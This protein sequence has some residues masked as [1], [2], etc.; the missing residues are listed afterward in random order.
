[1]RYFIGFLVTVGLVII[2]VILLFNGGGKSKVP[3][4]TKTLTDYATTDSNVSMTIAGPIN[5]VSVHREQ[6]VTVDRNNVTFEQ[7]TG[8]DGQVVDTQVFANT[9]SAYDAFLHALQH[10]GFTRGNNSKALQ[11]DVG[12]CSTGER[13][14]F[15]LNDDGKRLQRYWSSSC[16]SPKTYQGSLNLTL[17]L[18]QAQV[19]NYSTLS[20]GV[21]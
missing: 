8:Y 4:T 3:H 9:D 12:F 14:I 2:L 7:M 5:A 13:Y 1:M 15:E 19:P 20:T 6:R 16:G 17:T 18:F 11:D 21:H 10:A